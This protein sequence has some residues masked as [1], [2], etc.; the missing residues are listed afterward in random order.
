VLP[1]H[2]EKSVSEPVLPQGR[3]AFGTTTCLCC[4]ATGWG[5]RAAAKNSF[6][7]FHHAE[8][9][10]KCLLYTFGQTEALLETTVKFEYRVFD[11]HLFDR[12]RR[13]L[14]EELNKLGNDG[15]ELVATCGMHNQTF[16]FVRALEPAKKTKAKSD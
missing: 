15:W 13:E 7:H 11:S 5:T 3:G 10:R 8:C 14:E 6:A 4:S 2:G 1:A 16:L 9:C 12:P